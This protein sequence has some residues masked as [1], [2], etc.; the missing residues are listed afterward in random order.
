MGCQSPIAIEVRVVNTTDVF[1]EE[2]MIG[3]FGGDC[4]CHANIYTGLW[5]YA[6]P[7]GDDGTTGTC[8]TDHEVRKLFSYCRSSL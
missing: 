7:D 6:D 3:S 5:C 4:L 8:N 2:E 1:S